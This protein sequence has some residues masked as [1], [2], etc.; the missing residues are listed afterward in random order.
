MPIR[1]CT[2]MSKR[3]HQPCRARAMRGSEV[4]YHHGGRSRSGFA[5]PNYKYGFY[6]KQGDI[7]LLI[8]FDHYRRSLRKQQA[9][10]VYNQ[11]ADT[12]S[13]KTVA[14]Y[15]R[16][17]AAFRVMMGLIAYSPNRVYSGLFQC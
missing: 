4:C 6:C 10:A 8:A 17:M 7:L 14:D 12:L 3:T 5:H 15:R 1:Y 9:E 2:A 16:F 11:L 13:T